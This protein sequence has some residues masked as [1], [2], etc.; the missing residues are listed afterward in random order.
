M[1]I[2]FKFSWRSMKRRILTLQVSLQ[3]EQN[4]FSFP[5]KQK[6]IVSVFTTDSAHS[7]RSVISCCR[8]CSSS[9]IPRCVLFI[10][11]AACFM[12][13]LSSRE[14]WLLMWVCVCMLAC[15]HVRACV[16]VCVFT[17]IVAPDVQVELKNMYNALCE[18]LRHFWTCFPATSK[19]LEDKV[20]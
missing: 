9:Y 10:V 19:F 11:R 6:I 16:C 7:Q 5:Y 18:L 3:T 8:C 15:V 14:L 12:Y 1:C 4:C 20:F 13:W 2:L 17:G